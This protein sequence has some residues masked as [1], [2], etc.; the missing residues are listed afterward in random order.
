MAAMGRNFS[1]IWPLLQIEWWFSCEWPCI[2]GWLVHFTCDIRLGQSFLRNSKWL[3]RWLLWGGLFNWYT[4]GCRYF[5]PIYNKKLKITTF[6]YIY[7]NFL[8]LKFLLF[9]QDLQ[10]NLHVQLF[11]FLAFCLSKSLVLNLSVHC[12]CHE[13]LFFFMVFSIC[14]ANFWRIILYKAISETY[15]QWT[16]TKFAIFWYIYFMNIWLAY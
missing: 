4:N 2:V 10:Y 9:S 8:L 7:F 15:C 1:N 12:L 13:A 6:I 5:M 16:K 14:W 11:F 3:P